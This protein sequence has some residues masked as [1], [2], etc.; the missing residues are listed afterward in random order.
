[1]KIVAVDNSPWAQKGESRE[2]LLKIPTVEER[3]AIARAA[4]DSAVSQAR[5]AAQTQK[6]LEQRTS[7]AARDRGDRGAS[8][9]SPS[10]A[11]DKKGSMSYEAA[12]KFYDSTDYKPVLEMRLKAGKSKAII[13]DGH[14]G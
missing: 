4:A 12:E 5:A 2:L 8:Q 9:E 3:R 14:S 11:G 13:V 7:E 10:N 1:M 6:S